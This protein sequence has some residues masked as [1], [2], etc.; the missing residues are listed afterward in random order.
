MSWFQPVAASL[1]AAAEPI[2]FFFRDDDAGWEDAA[3]LQLLDV[4]E[5]CGAPIDL[6]AIPESLDISLA[7]ELSKRLERTA[8]RV[9][10][11]G[12]R[13]VNHQRDGRR[14]EFGSDRSYVQQHTDIVAGK[15][16]LLDLFAT[17]DPIFT[18]PWNRCT[19]ATAACLA[20]LSFRVLSC[21]T[22]ASVHAV[23]GLDEVPVSVDWFAK[24][25]VGQIGLDD[26]GRVIA[27]RSTLGAPVG[28]MLHHGVT[29]ASDLVA[30][31]Q[32][33]TLLMGHPNANVV[34]L[35]ATLD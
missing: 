12:R 3:L 20:E 35:M 29:D 14:C 32:F 24:G 16:K 23:P 34:A 25:P 8:V 10:Q 18:P 19:E 4:F 21:D 9:H 2:T 26:L 31:G 27:R 7:D 6:A 1:D 13:H 15:A 28:V 33:V 11:H 30:I 22:T 17:I 5:E